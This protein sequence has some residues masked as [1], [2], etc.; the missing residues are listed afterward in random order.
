VLSTTP[1]RLSLSAAGDASPKSRQA[2]LDL[3]QSSAAAATPT[4]PTEEA[5]IIAEAT[6]E[7][8][9]EEAVAVAEESA[10]V[11]DG[12]GDGAGGDA[13]GSSG[14]GGV[15]GGGGGGRLAPLVEGG[16][17]RAITL[18][19]I[20]ALAVVNVCRLRMRMR[21]GSDVLILCASAREA[22]EWKGEVQ[23]ARG[24][25]PRRAF[26]LDA[27]GQVCTTIRPRAPPLLPHHLSAL[28]RVP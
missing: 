10:N 23:R 12:D 24:G 5:G 11:T 19:S 28:T 20:D 27:I 1:S 21:D 18:A 22:L 26:L 17:L 3:I 15:S 9:E 16:V 13:S 2:L 14:D 25:S 4:E 8:T 6:G 7:A